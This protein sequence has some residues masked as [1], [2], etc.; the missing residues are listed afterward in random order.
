MNDVHNFTLI[1]RRGFNKTGNSQHSLFCHQEQKPA[2]K[3]H[4][5]FFE[6]ETDVNVS[7]EKFGAVNVNQDYLQSLDL[8]LSLYLR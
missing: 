8:G 1:G 7:I 2:E 5:R 3:W 4:C 6:K